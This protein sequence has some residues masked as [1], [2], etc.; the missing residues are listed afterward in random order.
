M[1][2]KFDEQLERLHIELIKMGALC[3]EAVTTA[4]CALEK[5]NT[6]MLGKVFEVDSEIDQAEN[7]LHETF[8]SAAAGC[9]RFESYFFRP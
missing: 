6:E 7:D 4:M 2:N 9:H 1:R 5:N 3:E 8:A